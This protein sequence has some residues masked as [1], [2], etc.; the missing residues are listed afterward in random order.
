MVGAIRV[1]I[2]DRLWEF[3]ADER[4]LRLAGRTLIDAS[5]DLAGDDGTA[6]VEFP[7]PLVEALE[8]LVE[9]RAYALAQG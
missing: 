1:E 5:D 8:R 9:R 7:A 2:G 4:G 6:R 3:P